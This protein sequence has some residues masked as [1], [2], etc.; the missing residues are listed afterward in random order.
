[1]ITKEQVQMGFEKGILNLVANPEMET[2]TVCMIGNQWFCIS[3]TADRL[4]PEEYLKTVSMPIVYEEV[5]KALDGMDKEEGFDDMYSYCAA[6]LSLVDEE[7]DRGHNIVQQQDKH[8]Y[9]A[10]TEIMKAV[11]IQWD[12][13]DPNDLEQLPK[14]IEIPSEMTDE[15]EISDYITNFTG[16][17]HKGFDI[18]N[19]KM[20]LLTME[21]TE[22]VGVAFYAYD[23]DDAE[24][25]ADRIY[26]DAMKDPSGFS[27]AEVEGDY[28]ICDDDGR[29]I[30]DWD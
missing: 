17:C 15:E 2:G 12:V 11:N 7:P 3:D 6:V 5:Y 8:K 25:Q 4:S 1:M 13:D 28:A 26:K 16:F 22:R 24:E 27:G 18:K 19:K 21:R 10:G 14:E 29:T 20:Y 23:D 9:Q 30:L